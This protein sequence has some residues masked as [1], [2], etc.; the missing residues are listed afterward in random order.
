M[1]QIPGVS[2]ALYVGGC[3]VL[4]TPT[5]VTLRRELQDTVEM[6]RKSSELFREARRMLSGSYRE[7]F[8]FKSS[9]LDYMMWFPDHKVICEM[10]QSAFYHPPRH[11]LIY[12]DTS[13][14]TPP[15]FARL[16]LLTPSNIPNVMSS[17]LKRNNTVY[18]SSSLFRSRVQQALTGL[19][20]AA[21]DENMHGPC[22]NYTYQSIEYD[23]A[24]CFHSRHWPLPALPWVERCLTRGWPSRSVLQTIIDD[25][26]HLVPIASRLTNENS[27]LEWRISFSQAEQKL[28][29]AMDHCQFLCYG[30]MKI[31]LK[32]VI[33]D[34]LLCSYFMKTIIFW[35]IQEN[36]STPWV[37]SILL[38]QVWFCFKYLVQCVYTGCLPNFF[39]PENNMFAGKVVG[40]QQMS[41]YQKLET[42]YEKG[43]SFLLHSPTLSEI[44]FPALADQGF[45]MPTDESS[46]KPM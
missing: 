37:P 25:G 36:F 42:L 17:L 26:F 33:C 39:I 46:L 35:R 5:E 41:L 18:I 10:S 15:G 27:D 45:F 9:D 34:K 16:Q 44:L 2:D 4:G 24:L 38:R 29:S 19:N 22:H 20:P 12:M 3:G 14:D 32:E 7:G 31:I 40:A 28:V 13:D 21:E 1:D 11:T 6:V 8:R 23:V 30:I 43:Y